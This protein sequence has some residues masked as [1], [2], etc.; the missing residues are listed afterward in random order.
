MHKYVGMQNTNVILN[1]KVRSIMKQ[2]FYVYILSTDM[3]ESQR[4]PNV[5]ISKLT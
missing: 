4:N 5:Y 3:H 1:K 2:G